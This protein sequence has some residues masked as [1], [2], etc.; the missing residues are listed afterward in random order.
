MCICNV[1]GEKCIGGTGGGDNY[2]AC[3]VGGGGSGDLLHC[4]RRGRCKMP[5]SVNFSFV[6]WEEINVFYYFQSLVPV[7]VTSDM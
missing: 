6:T 2:S 7:F 4:N 3:Y 1:S 5:L